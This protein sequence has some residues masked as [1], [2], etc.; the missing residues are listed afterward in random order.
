M[1]SWWRIGCIIL[2]KDGETMSRL[3]YILLGIVLLALV[4]YICLFVT[5]G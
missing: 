2:V 4:L 3:G 5:G 1:L